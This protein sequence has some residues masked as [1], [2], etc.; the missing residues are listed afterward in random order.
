MDYRKQINLIDVEEVNVPIN[1]IGCGALGSWLV[2][3]LLKMG[4]NE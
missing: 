1:V 2:L 3:F 4:E